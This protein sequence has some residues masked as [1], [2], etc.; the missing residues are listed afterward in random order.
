VKIIAASIL[1]ADMG[2][3]GEEVS[4]AEHAGADWVH[5]DVMDGHFVPNLSVGPPVVRAL[6]RATTLPIEVHL[7]LDNADRYLDVFL[8]AGADA[9]SVH[10]EAQP[11]LQRSIERLHE[12]GARAG[13][14][15]NPATPVT[16]LDEVLPEL[17]FVLVMTVNPGFG[18]Q[19]LLPR[20]L[21]KVR[22][23]RRCIGAKNLR[24][25]IEAD[26]GI[27]E[28]NVREVLAAGVDIVVAGAAV[29][30]SGNA[31]DGARRLLEAGSRA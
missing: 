27:N 10:A 23:L 1:S 24:T 20:T 7:M 14:A 13:V 26:G 30:A 3:L 17:D 18:G 22:G 11:H 25:S 29:F 12:R 16:V 31:E 28:S 8:D 21:D 2:R 9:I 6:R 19:T 15:L 4:A 5:V